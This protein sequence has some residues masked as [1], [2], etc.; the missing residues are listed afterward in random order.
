MCQFCNTLSSQQSG[1][2]PRPSLG[3][4]STSVLQIASS[5]SPGEGMQ[6]KK[7][8]LESFLMNHGGTDS[9]KNTD[10]G[11]LS[12]L[13][14]SLPKIKTTNLSELASLLNGFSIQTCPRLREALVKHLSTFQAPPPEV[15]HLR[16]CLRLDHHLIICW[17]TFPRTRY[18]LQDFL[19]VCIF[20][21][22]PHG[23]VLSKVRHPAGEAK[24]NHVLLDQIL[25]PLW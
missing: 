5:T 19:P 20:G 14:L 10:I 9:E 3:A 21:G 22:G 23:R 13:S 4:A 24:V 18:H 8:K 15:L 12:A 11:Q 1:L 25:V 2:P 17:A 7:N 16:D 6:K